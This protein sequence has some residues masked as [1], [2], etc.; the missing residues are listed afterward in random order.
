MILSLDAGAAAEE[1]AKLLARSGDAASLREPLTA[2]AE[3]LGVRL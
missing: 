1:I 2:L 3:R